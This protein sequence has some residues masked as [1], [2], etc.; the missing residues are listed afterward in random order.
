MKLVYSN[1]RFILEASR[2]HNGKY[3]YSKTLYKNGL[4]LS[5]SIKDAQEIS[6]VRWVKESEMNDLNWVYKDY[7]KNTLC[8]Q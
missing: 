5:L 2:I 4:S 7:L 1:K 8:K 3:D 6:E